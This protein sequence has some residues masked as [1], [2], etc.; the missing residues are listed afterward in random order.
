MIIIAG[1]ALHIS[2]TKLDVLYEEGFA[3]FFRAALTLKGVTHVFYAGLTLI[4]ALTLADV[5]A[6]RVEARTLPNAL[7]CI[8][9]SMCLV[10]LVGSIARWLGNAVLDTSEF[11]QDIAMKDKDPALTNVKLIIVM[12]RHTVLAKDYVLYVVPTSD[13]TKFESAAKQTKK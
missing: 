13:I 2:A 8:I 5:I 9:M 11:N 4:C 12:S 6:E 7:Q 1:T 10:L 3:H